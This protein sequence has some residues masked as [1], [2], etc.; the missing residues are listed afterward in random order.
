METEVTTTNAAAAASGVTPES[1]AFGIRP[2]TGRPHSIRLEAG[3]LAREAGSGSRGLDILLGIGIGA[4]AMYCL[5]PIGR[6][7]AESLPRPLD[8]ELPP[9]M[10]LVL[11]GLG[12]ALTLLGARRRDATGTAMGVLGSALLAGGARGPGRS[13]AERVLRL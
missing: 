9:A 10:R 7:A 8:T 11:A 4:A 2:S 5:D 12:T 6:R 1:V 13:A 3:A